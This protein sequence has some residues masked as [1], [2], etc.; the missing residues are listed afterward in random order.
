M[1]V[2]INSRGKSPISFQRFEGTNLP[3]LVVLLVFFDAVQEPRQCHASRLCVMHPSSASFRSL[4]CF[5]ARIRQPR[6]PPCTTRS[7]V[8]ASEIPRRQRDLSFIGKP[9][10][11]KVGCEVQRQV[12][13]FIIS[14]RGNIRKSWALWLFASNGCR[15]AQF[16][17]TVLGAAFEN[18]PPGSPNITSSWSPSDFSDDYIKPSFCNGLPHWFASLHRPRW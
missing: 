9:H 16:S 18:A 13:L 14:L 11:L 5:K 4:T 15:R 12:L 8:S 7:T 2:R 17:S 10:V 1:Y 6:R 3:Q